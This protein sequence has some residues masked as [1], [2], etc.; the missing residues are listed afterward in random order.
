[1]VR[2]GTLS[3]RYSIKPVALTCLGITTI[4]ELWA[5]IG[6]E[7]ETGIT[8]LVEAVRTRQPEAPVSRDALLALLI[9]DAVAG[10]KQSHE[11]HPFG[12]WLGLKPLWLGLRRV[13]GLFKQLVAYWPRVENRG[14]G[15]DFFW[16]IPK[17]CWLRSQEL[18]R[19]RA[20]AWPD[21]ALIILPILLI[22][23]GIVVR[24][25][26]RRRPMNI[27]VKRGATLIPFTA[28]D[29]QNLTTEAKGTQ[30]GL[31]TS[32][33][34]LTGRYPLVEIRAGELVR[35]D[36]LVSTEFAGL[37]RGRHI[38]S[39]PIKGGLTPAASPLSKIKLML[40]PH[41]KIA[42][43]VILED[44]LILAVGKEGERIIVGVDENNLKQL[45]SLVGVSDVYVVQEI[46]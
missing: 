30:S 40:S 3:E 26:D 29:P 32:K 25:V 23:A 11:P 16:M 24:M 35:T 4:D 7:P 20:K 46:K 8:K 45:R 18:W 33:G 17:R 27:G 6:N 31:F 9:T 14:L 5:C 15:L 38:L 41:D 10:A 43:G 19:T 34:D 13:G 22:A 37:L 44:V 39:L 21:L 1:M 12:W 2:I 36:Q 28:I 42:E